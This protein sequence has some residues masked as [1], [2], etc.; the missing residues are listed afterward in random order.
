[1]DDGASLMNVDWIRA[2]NDW[3]VELQTPIEINVEQIVG[4]GQPLT[5]VNDTNVTGTLTGTPATAL[6]KAVTITFGWAGLLSVARGGTGIGS[7]AVGDLLYAS[8]GA[9]LSKLAGVAAGSYLR[10]GGVTTAPVWST[11]TLPNSAV[12]GD[13]LYASGAN[14]M[15][16]RAIGSAN[17]V[18]TVAGG[19]PTWAPPA[20]AATVTI[21]NDTTTNASMFPTWVTANTGNLPLKV[22][23]TKLS[24]NPSTGILALATALPVT[25]GGTGLSAAATGD[26]L[27]G[28][29]ANTLSRLA[30]G[31]STN[32]LTVSGGL[33]VWAAPAAAGSVTIT[34]DTTTNATMYPTWVTAAS[35]SLPLKVSSTKLSF[36]PSTGVLALATPLVVTSGGTGTG[37]AFT[38]GSVVFAGASGVYTQD[39]ANFFY[40]ISNG[41]LGLGTTSPSSLI[42][43]KSTSAFPIL[44]IESTTASGGVLQLTSSANNWQ[45]SAA[46]TRMTFDVNPGG[47]KFSFTD[48]GV[49]KIGTTSAIATATNTLLIGDGTAPG[50]G[51]VP[52]NVIA[53]YTDVATTAGLFAMDENNQISRL[54]GPSYFPSTL[55][56][57]LTTVTAVLH[58]KGGT[59][60]ANTA[61]LKF[62]SGT[63]LT[64]AEAGAME[65]NG[66]NLFFTRAG[67]VR[68]NVMVA[69]DN[70]AA[71]TT[72]IGVGIVNYYGSSATN[73]LGDPNRWLSVNVLGVVYKIPLYT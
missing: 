58:L 43:V 61:P 5:R 31:S 36:N 68:E 38:L 26:L 29:A 51:S 57:G 63:N 33:P 49:V 46:S 9:T 24:F 21:A 19:L 32:V 41:R 6:L 25:S 44:N 48:A 28:S 16:L 55:G 30:I 65:Y 35:G 62:T 54:T 20:A 4:G 60:T 73:F 39:N 11:L 70:A 50:A 15:A 2:F 17:D 47:T 37:T 8:A 7:Y 59:A 53:V 13:L 3:R 72:S 66:T 34:D 14:A 10:S 56:I 42:H 27:Y 69:V 45:I 23:S 18:L 1:M 67:T 12:T 40:N 22:T 71:P 52:A 64:T